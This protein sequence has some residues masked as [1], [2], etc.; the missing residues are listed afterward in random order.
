MN[1][2][3]LPFLPISAGLL[4]S[5]LLIFNAGIVAAQSVPSSEEN[6]PYLVTFGKES[7]T[8]WGDDDFCQTFFFIIPK[9]EKKPIFIRVFDPDTGGDFDEIKEKADTK[10][11]YSIFGGKGAFT[12]HDAVLE[13]P[14]GQYKSGTL[15]STKI[16]DSNK[17]FNG[18]WYSFGP[19][20]PTEGEYIEEHQGYVIKLIAEGIS[21]NDGNL[22]K[23][24]LSTD[25]D[26]NVKV[27]GA[28]MFTFEYT[29]RLQNEAG[30]V[31][32]IYPFVNKDVVS[33]KIH[34][35]DFDND[36]MVRIVSVAK[37]FEIINVSGDDHW[38]ESL[39]KIS[40]AEKNTSLDIQMIKRTASKDNNVVFYI[41]NQYGNL[42]PFFTSPI[43]GAP[44]IGVNIGVRP[45]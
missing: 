32:H 28:N 8:S 38:K 1:Q 40:D 24:F 41:T 18:K 20:N 5:C 13:Q 39:H 27:E 16:F 25:K 34:T 31:S 42:L 10:T 45:K 3:R 37:K 35:F 7:M 43:G 12:N 4:L 6:I 22:Y 9:E 33:I 14:V 15:L 17:D 19:F 23:Y 11:R 44:K 29:F 2:T 30:S 26:N 36:G 21:G